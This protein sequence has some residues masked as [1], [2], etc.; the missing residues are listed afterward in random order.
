MN[1]HRWIF[2]TA[3]A[4]ALT[5]VGCTKQGSVDTAALEKSFKSA[6]P[7]TQTSAD[8]VVSAVKAIDYQG[9]MAELKTLA[10]NAKLTPDQQQAVK[11]VVAQVE[12][13]LADVAAKAKG[14][15]SKAADD[16][17]KSLPK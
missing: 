11:D 3:I 9:A 15:A 12:K 16:L 13:A 8:K 6:D 2:A 5:L 4:A 10:S 1:M 14:E 17:K 7:A